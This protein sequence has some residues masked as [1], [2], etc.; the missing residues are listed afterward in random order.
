MVLGG[1]NPPRSTPGG[2]GSPGGS[3]VGPRRV[4]GKPRGRPK[5]LPGH[6]W[7]APRSPRGAPRV[8]QSHPEAPKSTPQRGKWSQKCSQDRFSSRIWCRTTFE[9][10]FRLIFHGFSIKIV[11]DND[12]RIDR[13]LRREVA[14]KR[15]SMSMA[16]T[17]PTRQKPMSQLC[18]PKTK[19]GTATRKID[20][21][22][23]ENTIE[24][25]P[26]RSMSTQPFRHPFW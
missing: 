11:S 15:P 2:P 24:K 10:D 4:P 21:T 23:I 5:R 8:A 7:S 13:E 1:H 3:Q 19:L 20:K 25:R 9:S 26:A 18:S 22:N 12:W 17:H 6:P 16:N 14:S